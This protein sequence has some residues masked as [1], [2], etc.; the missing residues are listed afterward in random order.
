MSTAPQPIA[1]GAEPPPLETLPRPA[2]PARHPDRT[3]P[4][5]KPGQA[6]G[7]FA[8]LNGFVDLTLRRI[9][10]TAACV[11]LVLYRDTKPDGLA[12]TSQTDLAR[13]TGRSVRTVYAALRK[14]ERLGLLIIVRK[15]G[16]NIGA[17]IY[18]VRAAPE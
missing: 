15:G 18:R 2:G 13:R 4:K 5:R 12:R 16:L 1:V 9:V 14:L 11:W 6:G 17:T 8:V 7:R 3:K 10:P